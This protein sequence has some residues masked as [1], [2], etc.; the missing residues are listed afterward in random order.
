MKYIQKILS[1]NYQNTLTT[2]NSRPGLWSGK[3][4]DGIWG[5]KFIG[6]HKITSGEVKVSPFKHVPKLD[7]PNDVT[8]IPAKKI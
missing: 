3:N 6:Q 2:I 5:Q 1:V 4:N 8:T 7:H